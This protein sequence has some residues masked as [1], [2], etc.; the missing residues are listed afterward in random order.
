[1]PMRR[2]AAADAGG[3]LGGGVGAGAVPVDGDH[4]GVADYPG[5]V[6]GGEGGDLAGDGVELG[7]VGKTDPKLSGHVVLEVRRF[8]QVGAG[9]GLDVLGPAPAWLQ[10]QA[11]DV[12]AVD[13]QYFQ[14]AAG[15]FAHFV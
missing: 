6:A 2:G 11:P 15:E 8:A 9:G 5:V 1:M 3:G 12:A 4:G 10:H 14:D 7:A 13:V